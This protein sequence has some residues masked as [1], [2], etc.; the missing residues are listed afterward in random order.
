VGEGGTFGI[1]HFGVEFELNEFLRRVGN[2]V[3][4]GVML[5]LVTEFW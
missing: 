4:I 2:E 5:L 1:N 3:A